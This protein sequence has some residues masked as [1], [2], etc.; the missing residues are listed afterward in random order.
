MHLRP[1]PLFV[2]EQ[3][4]PSAVK[5][6]IASYPSWAAAVS[7]ACADTTM[8]DEVTSLDVLG[9]SPAK[10]SQPTLTFQVDALKLKLR[11]KDELML[12]LQDG[13]NAEF[14]ARSIEGHVDF[15]PVAFDSD[16][17]AGF[18]AAK[19]GGDESG[20]EQGQDAKKPKQGQALRAA[21]NV[22]QWLANCLP[23]PWG[24]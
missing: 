24:Q 7:L 20:Q 4:G 9:A 21:G 18:A 5:R 17:V 12:R 22:I 3:T 6:C 16:E 10:Y 11:E 23:R 8:N 15:P 1:A 2:R 13:I 19:K 14:S